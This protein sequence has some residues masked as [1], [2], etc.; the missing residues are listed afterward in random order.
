VG[1]AA[2]AVI[3]LLGWADRE[4]GGLFPVEGAEPQEVGAAF[5][6]RY[7][8]P[9]DIDDVGSCNDFLDEGFWYLAAYAHGQES[10]WQG[11]CNPLA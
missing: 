10:S 7:M 5:A 11:A 2:E 8:P 3:E 9:H 1:S 6:Q 4:A